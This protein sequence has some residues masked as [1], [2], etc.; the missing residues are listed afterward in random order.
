MP[1][2]HVATLQMSEHYLNK[3]RPSNPASGTL[4]VDMATL[5]KLHVSCCNLI[6]MFST[7]QSWDEF[8]VNFCVTYLNFPNNPRSTYLVNVITTRELHSFVSLQEYSLFRYLW[9]GRCCPLTF[10]TSP[11]S[12]GSMWQ[13]HCEP[14]YSSEFTCIM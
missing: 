6:G 4:I 2:W 11:W 9:H 5:C 12:N 10:W 1:L 13:T 8:Y 14:I 7:S 3:P